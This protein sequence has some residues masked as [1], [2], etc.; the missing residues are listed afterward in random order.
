MKWLKMIVKMLK[1][2]IQITFEVKISAIKLC[3]ML[4]ELLSQQTKYKYEFINKITSFAEK[5]IKYIMTHQNKT[6]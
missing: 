3:P 6:A 5:D 1:Y 4:E 2:L